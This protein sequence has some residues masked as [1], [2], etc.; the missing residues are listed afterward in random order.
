MN[1]K[2]E[3]N[4]EIGDR[5]RQARE[6]AGLTQDK[7]SE[8][9]GVS[10]QYISDLE[11]GIVGTS[12]YTFKKIC[13]ALCVSSDKLLFD[14]DAE[15]SVISPAAERVNHIPDEYKPQMEK[16]INAALEIISMKKEN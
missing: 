10:P 9:I 13:K 14:N 2:K 15:N 8:L 16:M 7:L 5:I 4:I 12:L 6:A 3:L 11:R 1:V